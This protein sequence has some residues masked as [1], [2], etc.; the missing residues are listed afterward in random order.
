MRY[1]CRVSAP[2]A[3]GAPGWLHGLLALRFLPALCI[4]RGK[5]QRSVRPCRAEGLLV[6][7]PPPADHLTNP[8]D[9]LTGR[10][11]PVRGT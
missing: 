10:K 8:P 2:F 11:R 5:Q 7:L 9:L 4:T 6:R 1:S 3:M